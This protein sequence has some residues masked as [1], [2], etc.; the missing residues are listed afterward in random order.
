MHGQTDVNYFIGKIQNL[1]KGLSELEMD[2]V[3]KFGEEYGGRALH[4][5][6]MHQLRKFL[7]FL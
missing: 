3:V 7:D 4:S 6:Q 1:S 5:E 2:D